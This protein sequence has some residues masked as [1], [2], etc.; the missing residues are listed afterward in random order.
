MKTVGIVMLFGLCTMIGMQ[1]GAKK[2]A[3]LFTVRTL[4]KELQLFSERITSGRGTLMEIASEKDGMLSEMLGRY[5]DALGK[6]DT[7][8]EAAGKAA[9][10]L[11]AESTEHAGMLMF[12]TG[13]STGSRMD[14]IGRANALSP[15][16]GRA[17]NEAE[18]EAKQARVLR[19]SGMLI[20]AGVA[21]LLI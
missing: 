5:L 4:R 8:P 2:T 7:E 14:L 6:G 12:F 16:L 20:G 13:L 10:K 9:G 3:R 11:K 15:T 19:V 18:A 21:I 17:E 1:L